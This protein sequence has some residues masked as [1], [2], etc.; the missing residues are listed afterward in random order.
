M[1]IFSNKRKP[2]RRT[3]KNAL[4]DFS[5]MNISS[6]DVCALLWHLHK[7]YDFH[8]I[9]Y[10]MKCNR[11]YLNYIDDCVPA[12]MRAFFDD[13]SNHEVEELAHWCGKKYMNIIT[14]NPK[15]YADGFMSPEVFMWKELSEDELKEKESR[16]ADV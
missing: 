13:R 9:T 6:H 14:C 5:I 12:H 4:K 16:G 11:C 10:T 1:S 15:Y 7:V 3:K 2:W 8:H